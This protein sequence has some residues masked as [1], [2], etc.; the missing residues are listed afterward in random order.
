MLKQQTY[1][2]TW[3]L[4]IIFPGGSKSKEFSTYLQMIEEE[5]NKLSLLVESFH[6]DQAETFVES[7]SQVVQQLESTIKKQREAFA[8]ISCLNAQDMQDRQAD[9]LVGKQ[10]ELNAQMRSIRTAFDQKLV[11]INDN[12]W[13]KLL[14]HEQLED[15]SFVL[16]EYRTNAKEK[17]PV[18]QEVLINDLAIDGYQGWS[19]MYDAIVGQMNIEIEEDGD[20]QS[21]SVGQVANKLSDPDR[22]VRKHVFEQLDEAWSDRSELFGQTLN[23]LAGFRLQTYKHRHWDDVLKEPLSI[24]RMKKETLDIMWSTIAKNKNPF[25]T[26]LEK[27]ADL[28]GLD[29]LSMYDIGAPVSKSVQTYTYT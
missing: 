9:L 15:V 18:E 24:N 16:N 26:F 11:N 2:P 22:N 3:D 23:H 8:Y 27:K 7:L 10:N 19:Q 28:L 1:D 14:E 17:L 25:V 13:E 6:P 29:K 21:Y 4:D 12:D 20:V 5:M